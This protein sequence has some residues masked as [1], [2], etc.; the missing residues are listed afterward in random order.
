VDFAFGA[1]APYVNFELHPPFA[2]TPYEL[3]RDH[4]FYPYPLRSPDW[5]VDTQLKYPQHLYSIKVGAAV[6][7]ESSVTP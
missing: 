1:Y 5:T 6:Q 2:H 3:T 7:V 4:T